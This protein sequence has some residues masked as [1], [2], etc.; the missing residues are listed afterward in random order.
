MRDRRRTRRRWHYLVMEFLDGLE[1]AR[2][3]VAGNGSRVADACRIVGQAALGLAYVHSWFGTRDIK[4]SNIMVT[5]A[6]M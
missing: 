2:L 6:A 1:L 4:P 5:R 3:P